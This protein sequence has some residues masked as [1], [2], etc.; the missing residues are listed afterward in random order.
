MTL[1]EEL[2]ELI[3]SKPITDADLEAA[4]WLMLDGLANTVGGTKKPLAEAFAKTP[5]QI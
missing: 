3:E 5:M 1:T 4:A 2:I